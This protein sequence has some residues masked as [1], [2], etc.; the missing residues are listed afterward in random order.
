MRRKLFQLRKQ[1][2]EISKEKPMEALEYLEQA[3][4]IA[5]SDSYTL[6]AYGWLLKRIGDPKVFIDY[7][8]NLED[9]PLDL[10]IGKAYYWCIYDF[11]IKQYP[12]N[13]IDISQFISIA[14][15]IV[16]FCKKN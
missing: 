15:Q 8:D 12:D 4:R 1:A 14:E 3:L 13:D 10:N 11:Y 9:R 7:C 6:V 2:K 16:E 5:P